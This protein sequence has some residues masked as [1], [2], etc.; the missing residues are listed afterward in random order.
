MTGDAAPSSAH[1]VDEVISWQAVAPLPEVNGDV[2]GLLETIDDQRRVWEETL[3]F[4]THDEIE[5]ARKRTLRRHAI[6]TGIIERLYDVEWGVTEALVAEG[7]TLEA[8]ARDG[9]I[10]TETLTVIRDHYE[11]LD[12]L[13]EVARGTGPLT[14]YVIRQL[15]ELITRHQTSY[16]AKD[17]F[18]RVVLVPMPHGEWK[19]Q[20]NHAVRPDGTIIAF[21]PPEQVESAIEQ[22]L[23]GYADSVDAHPIV[24]AA[25]FHHQFVT[26]HPFADGNGRVARGL[27]LLTLLSNHYAPLVVTRRHRAEYLQSLDFATDGNLKPLIRLFARLEGVALRSELIRPMSAAPETTSVVDVARAYTDR[28]LQL[29]QQADGDKRQAVLALADAVHRRLGRHLATLRTELV[30]TFK[31]VDPRA[32][33]DVLQ[34]KPGDERAHWWRAQLVDTANAVDFFTNLNDGSWWTRFELQVFGER[35]CYVV[36]VQRMGRGE[37]GFLAVTAFAEMRSGDQEA[38]PVSLL[39][40]TADDAVTLVY[41][42]D[43]AARWPAVSDLVDRTMTAAVTR[44]AQTLG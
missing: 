30:E 31:A 33:G 5:A 8:A 35:L 28:L 34:S 25:W 15:H 29:R 2:A 21:A 43:D 4:A 24:R 41:S 10:A 19:R 40:L 27:T 14:P 38:R 23:R 12:Y 20:A 17:Q 13:S 26:I 7:L 22:L 1:G 44:F 39:D 9:G 42:D 18:N 32:N 16:E 6:E 36:A 3:A 37:S 11:A